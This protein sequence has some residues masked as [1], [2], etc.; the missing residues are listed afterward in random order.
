MLQR[1]HVGPNADVGVDRVEDD[2]PESPPKLAARGVKNPPIA[3]ANRSIENLQTGE[4]DGLQEK[5]LERRHIF[6]LKNS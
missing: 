5:L 1:L 6:E 3:D 4:N 2:G